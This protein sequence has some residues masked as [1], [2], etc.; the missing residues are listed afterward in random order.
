MSSTSGASAPRASS[1][2]RY[3]ASISTS[4]TAP[5]PVASGPPL[6]IA[7]IIQHEEPL[8]LTTVVSQS[9]ASSSSSSSSFA[10]LFTYSGFIFQLRLMVKRALGLR[11][12]VSDIERMEVNFLLTVQRFR[13]SSL[14]YFI[15]WMCDR[16]I[17]THP[18]YDASF[19][20][21]LQTVVA[22]YFVGFPLS[23][24]LCANIFLGFVLA[25][26]FKGKIPSDVEPRIKSRGRLSPSGFPCIEL[27]IVGCVSYAVV[28]KFPKDIYA[29]L[30]AI[31]TP[32]ILSLLRIYG[33]THFPSQLI[34]SLVF[35]GLTIPLYFN[36][37]L[38]FY[39]KGLDNFSHLLAILPPCLGYIGYVAY[40]VETNEMPFLRTPKAT[41]ERVLGDIARGDDA[42]VAQDM[43][44]R[45]R[46]RRGGPSVDA[47]VAARMMA[48]EEAERQQKSKT[49]GRKVAFAPGFAPPSSESEGGVESSTR[50]FNSF[51]E[52]VDGAATSSRG[53]QPPRGPSMTAN[54]L[55]RESLAEV[56][57]ELETPSYSSP[58]TNFSS[59]KNDPDFVPSSSSTFESKGGEIYD[60]DTGRTRP[61]RDSFYYLMQSARKKKTAEELGDNF[62]WSS[63]TPI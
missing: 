26:I 49:S 24:C 33:C 6:V 15:R 4:E 35:G 27:F 40:K 51:R 57:G 20:A 22:I 12:L 1:V 53:S 46:R 16:M 31:L 28:Y 10:D 30:G 3:T 25:R 23:W 45:A 14:P 60:E 29:I 36:I 19:A 47:A 56:L 61:K 41:F 55:A 5:I 43:P 9:R 11:T 58:R 17:S 34:F 8:L 13:R 50:R 21:W 59:F 48:Q 37:G 2:A 39:P 42:T 54:N 7:P 63:L 44:G 62:S 52:N 32:L 18:F 38:Y